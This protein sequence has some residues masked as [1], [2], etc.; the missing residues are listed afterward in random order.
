VNADDRELQ[1]PI[2]AGGQSRGLLCTPSRPG[3][4]EVPQELLGIA[5]ITRCHTLGGWVPFQR[6]MMKAPVHREVVELMQCAGGW[7]RCCTPV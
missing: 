5:R 6:D 2:G 1:Y 7:T 4:H 3:T